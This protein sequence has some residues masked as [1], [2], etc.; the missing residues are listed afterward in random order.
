MGVAICAELV[1]NLRR[2]KDDPDTRVVVLT[3]A[4]EDAFSIGGDLAGRTTA[5]EDAI[6][7]VVGLHDSESHY[8]QLFGILAELGKPV[9]A[10]VNGFCLSTG[11]GLALGCDLIVAS[12]DSEFGTP[13]VKRGLMPMRVMAVLIRNCGRK[14]AM[15]MIL[16]GERIPALEAERLGLINY[17]VPGEDLDAKV[18]TLARPLAS[19]SPAALRL[20]RDAFYNMADLEFENA[21]TYLQAL[22]TLNLSMADAREG[23]A[24]FQEKRPPQ[25]QGR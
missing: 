16:T 7:D 8:T 20:G 9:I 12:N 15:E 4:G 6:E 22:W 3:G 24:S 1:E 5:M 11:L 19:A 13:E 14:K 23:I 21:L 18:D 17:A 25:W 2:A 10:R